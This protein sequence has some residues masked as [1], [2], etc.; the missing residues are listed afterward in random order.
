[1]RQKGV[2][3]TA[4]DMGAIFMPTEIL[5]RIIQITGST[6]KQILPPAR[7]DTTSSSLITVTVQIC[8][9]F[10]VQN[11]R[12][13]LELQKSG[14]SSRQ[15]VFALCCST[16]YVIIICHNNISIFRNN[17]E[18]NCYVCFAGQSH[19]ELSRYQHAIK[20]ISEVLS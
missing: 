18:A 3:E 7:L 13:D 17:L 19:I 10:S 8:W 9:T 5:Q 4:T 14:I 20:L 16:I 2:T 1:M 12:E 11:L 6:G 15:N